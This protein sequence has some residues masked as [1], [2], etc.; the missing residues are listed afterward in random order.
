VLKNEKPQQDTLTTAVEIIWRMYSAKGPTTAN[1]NRTGGNAISSSLVLYPL[2]VTCSH[3]QHGRLCLI[4][5]I[6]TRLFPGQNLFKN[7]PWTSS[8]YPNIW[9]LHF[10]KSPIF[11]FFYP[12][13]TP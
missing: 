6:F 1:Q 10:L 2:C 11:I 13:A 7:L 12:T 9:K 5:F 8:E 4:G 3:I